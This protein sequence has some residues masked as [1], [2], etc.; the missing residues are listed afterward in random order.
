MTSQDSSNGAR[1]HWDAWYTGR[2]TRPQEWHASFDD[3]RELIERYLGQRRPEEEVSSKDEC[4][5]M[6]VSVNCLNKDDDYN[7]DDRQH[8][9]RRRL[10]DIGAGTSSLGVDLLRHLNASRSCS[11]VRPRIE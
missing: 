10:I 7:D 11:G 1:Q 9:H 4:N 2:A 6:L 5:A 8:R 3:L